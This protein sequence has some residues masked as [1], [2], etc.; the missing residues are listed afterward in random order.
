MKNWTR[1][2]FNMV[3][4]CRPLLPCRLSAEASWRYAAL[5][6]LQGWARYKFGSIRIEHGVH[7]VSLSGCIQSNDAGYVTSYLFVLLQLYDV[8]DGAGLLLVRVRR[9]HLHDVD[10]SLLIVWQNHVFGGLVIRLS[11]GYDQGLVYLHRHLGNREPRHFQ[12]VHPLRDLGRRSSIY[13]SWR[14]QRHRRKALN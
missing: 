11:A 5:S 7:K 13:L 8:L 6:P 4:A 14:P 2:I 9:I 3:L 1:G 10:S 12:K